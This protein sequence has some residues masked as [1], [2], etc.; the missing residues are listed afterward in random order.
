MYHSSAENSP[1]QVR[2]FPLFEYQL[3]KNCKIQ[4]LYEGV[5]FEKRNNNNIFALVCIFVFIAPHFTSKRDELRATD[6]AENKVLKTL[7]VLGRYWYLL[8]KCKLQN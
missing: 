3:C 5:F 2:S 4:L 1:Q 6:R 8:T 7:L